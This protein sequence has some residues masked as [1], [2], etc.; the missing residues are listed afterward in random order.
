MCIYGMPLHPWPRSVST[1]REKHVKSCRGNTEL[2]NL[3]KYMENTEFILLKKMLS[4]FQKNDTQIFLF[5]LIS[6]I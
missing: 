3:W 4:L 1:N 2:Y 5:Q 6:L